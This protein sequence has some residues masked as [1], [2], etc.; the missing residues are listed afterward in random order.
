MT[1]KRCKKKYI[2][3]IIN[4][5]IDISKLLVLTNQQSKITKRYSIYHYKQKTGKY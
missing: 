2:I 5:S 4:T 3:F 1:L